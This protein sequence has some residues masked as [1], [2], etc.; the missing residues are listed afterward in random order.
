MNDPVVVEISYDNI[1]QEEG[2][3]IVNPD[4]SYWLDSDLLKIAV[5][6]NVESSIKVDQAPQPW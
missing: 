1:E 3:P 5:N 4:M 6:K 2:F